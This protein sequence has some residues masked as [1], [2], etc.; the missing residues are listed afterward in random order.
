MS[1]DTLSIHN[2]CEDATPSRSEHVIDA[3]DDSRGACL[4]SEAEGEFFAHSL[5]LVSAI[6]GSSLPDGYF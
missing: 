4:E 2:R 1:R 6:F 5:R 3:S